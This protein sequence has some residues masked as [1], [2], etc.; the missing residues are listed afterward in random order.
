MSGDDR[1][2]VLNYRIGTI[3]TDPERVWVW[4]PP[5]CSILEPRESSQKGKNLFWR[6]E[7]V[8]Q[9]LRTRI[10]VE[11]RLAS[12]IRL[13]NLTVLGIIINFASYYI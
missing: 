9:P 11:F 3:G 2:V 7:L 12:C 8:D 6:G 1:V 13:F 5:M 4:H 10:R